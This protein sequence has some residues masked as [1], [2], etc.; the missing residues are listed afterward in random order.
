MTEEIPRRYQRPRRFFSIPG[1]LIG[2]IL[3]IAGGLFFTWTLAPVQEFDTEPWQL[4]ADAKDQYIVAVALNYGHDNDLAGAINRLVGL[5]LPGDPVQAVADAACR[6]ATTGYV[7]SSGGLHAVRAMM[8]LYQL[9]GRTGCA[10]TLITSDDG[11][12][13]S[14]VTIEL[15]TPTPTL[16]P[17]PSKTPTSVAAFPTATPVLKVPRPLVRRLR[18]LCLL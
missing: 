4:K 7:N 12:P 9:Q 11:Q 14:V 8:K 17:P 1:I 5:Q 16:T 18:R 6:L 10:D 13:G 3:G 2:L 15:P